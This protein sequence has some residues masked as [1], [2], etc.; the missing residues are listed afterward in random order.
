MPGTA[1]TTSAAKLTLAAG[2]LLALAACGNTTGD[3]G[4]SGAAIGAGAGAVGGALVGA[5]LTGA[6]IGGAVGGATGA[7]TD[8]DDIDLGDPIWD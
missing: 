6:A 2:V 8:K 7:L 5:P 4:L 1:L 3:R